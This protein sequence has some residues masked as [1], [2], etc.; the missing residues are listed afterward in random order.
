MR[1]PNS[2]VQA[3]AAHRLPS[4]IALRAFE[5]AARLGSFQAAA[6]ELHV[7]PSAISHQIRAL[8]G[9]LGVPLF[10]RLDKRVVLARGGQELFPAV[11]EAMEL[12]QAAS[13]RVRRLAGERRLV[14]SSAPL[15]ATRWLMP[16]LADFH[17]RHP[18]WALHVRATLEEEDFRSGEI[19]LAIRWGDRD[20]HWP[21]HLAHERRLADSMRAL[22]ETNARLQK[23]NRLKDEF[24]ACMSHELRTPLHSVLGIA[25]VLAEAVGGSVPG[26]AQLMNARARQLGALN[27]H[28]ENPHGL[29]ND[30]HV[31]SAYDLAVIFRYAMLNPAFAKIVPENW[32]GVALGAGTASGSF[33]QFVFDERNHLAIIVPFAD[34][35]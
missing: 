33:G 28:F 4:L 13:L 18:D 2:S 21:Q 27:S 11:H 8:E 31:S 17:A 24:L 35:E 30:E 1:E 32:R 20:R 16:R 7:T 34:I 22:D 5:A 23:A 26:F 29:P 6:A 19:D 10:E 12:L 9:E 3:I 14:L 15:F 25:E